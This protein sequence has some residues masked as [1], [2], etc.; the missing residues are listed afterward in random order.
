MPPAIHKNYVWASNLFLASTAFYLL[1]TIYIFLKPLAAI[2]I[3]QGK[4]YGSFW[5]IAIMF[6]VILAAFIWV[7]LSMR[8]GKTWAKVLFSIYFA[9]SLYLFAR[10]LPILPQRGSW[11][12]GRNLLALCFQLS[13]AFFLFRN[14]L[15]KPESPDAGGSYD[16][17]N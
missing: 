16:P 15:R 6:A 13:I 5:A 8:S 10:E 12:I 11:D 7:G 9:W 4:D 14:K 3:A 1:P 2:T 17:P